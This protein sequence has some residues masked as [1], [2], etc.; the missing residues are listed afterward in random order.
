MS[1]R[2]GKQFFFE[3]KN[4]KT[5]DFWG[6][7]S[8]DSATAGIKVFC[9]FFSKKQALLSCLAVL[10]FA[11][12]AHAETL[13]DALADTYRTNPTLL[14]QRATQR[15]TDET[16]VQARAGWRPTISVTA[17]AGYAQQTNAPND[18]AAG[19]Y[20]A[21]DAQ[22]SLV[23]SQ[24]LYT[25]GRVAHAVQAAQARVLAGR[26]ALRASE[27][28]VLQAAI[29]AYEDVLR[30]QDILATRR[31]DLDT[32]TRQVAE[33][34]ARYRLGAGVTR[35]DVS[36]AAAQRAQADAAA[37]LAAAQLDASRAEFRAA[38][39]HAPGTLVQPDTLPRLPASLAEASDAA[40]EANPA[41][42]QAALLARASAADIGTARAAQAPLVSL[43][44]SYGYVGG[45]APLQPRR[46]DQEATA[47]VTLTAP[48]YAGGMVASQIR[49]AEDRNEADRAAEASAARTAEQ[50][51]ATAWS[52]VVNGRASITASQAQVQAA[53]TSLRG[54]QLE[55][56][57]G[58]RTTLDVLIADQN[59]RAAQVALAQTRHDTIL[60]EASLLS[61]LGRLET[62]FLVPGEPEYS[63]DAAFRRVRRKGGVPWEAA[64][65]ALDR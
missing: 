37:S 39:G 55:F 65:A 10:C 12:S 63:A 9:C 60:A 19:V 23:V 61:V 62:R 53:A 1:D 33:T 31:A 32:L 44:G 6:S 26:Q 7:V 48:I 58:L 57:D 42:G 3:K 2:Q 16:Y 52:A 59:L 51:V 46:Y 30:D 34:S 13:Q 20:E 47:L 29:T 22:A 21:N 5:F 17:N 50:G 38:V 56:A 25:G 54:Y 18:Y 15:A 35:T 43:Q 36:Q 14:G 27:A 40:A 28:Q 4:Q 41:L 8:G 64:V 24:P 49:Q 11:V 45:V